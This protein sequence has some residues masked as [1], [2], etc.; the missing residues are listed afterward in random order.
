MMSFTEC[1]NIK[2]DSVDRQQDTGPIS[3]AAL[4]ALFNI[5]K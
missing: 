3:H 5:T 1:Y 4:W 2:Q